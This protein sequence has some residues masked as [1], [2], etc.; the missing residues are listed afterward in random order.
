MAIGIGT[1]NILMPTIAGESLAD[2]IFKD[3]QL[4]EF[5]RNLGKGK[6]QVVLHPYI[7]TLV[8]TKIAKSINAIVKWFAPGFNDI[9]K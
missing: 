6:N 2:R 4:L 8:E 5:L 1:Q 7:S 3:E 9:N